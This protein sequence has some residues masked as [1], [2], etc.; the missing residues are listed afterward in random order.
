MQRRLELGLSAADLART[1]E[2][3]PKTLRSLERGEKWPWPVKRAA[4]EQALRW[5]AG[6]LDALRDGDALWE[7]V[8]RMDGTMG[9]TL[10]DLRGAPEPNYPT[11]DEIDADERAHTATLPLYERSTPD[12]L[13]EL[14]GR[15][16]E[17]ER[18]I[19]ELEEER[20]RLIAEIEHRV[21]VDSQLPPDP[22]T[23]GQWAADDEQRDA[24]ARGAAGHRGVA[25]DGV[26][27]SEELADLRAAEDVAVAE[28]REK[29]ARS[30]R[31][32]RERS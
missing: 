16:R 6:A 31:A 17:Q 1:A 15:Y 10:V 5:P 25:G 24:T 9:H 32:E 8:E 30:R 12:L 20:D 23:I 4:I 28:W 14:T 19:R 11:P 2:V 21:N 27:N 22:R 26:V 7:P 3:D 13:T 18:R 29:Q